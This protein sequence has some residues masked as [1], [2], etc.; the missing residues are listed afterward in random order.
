VDLSASIICKE[1]GLGVTWAVARVR[2]ERALESTIQGAVFEE[3][4]GVGVELLC[5]EG[6][7][8][9]ILQNQ[10]QRLRGSWL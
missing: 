1:Y 2:N 3:E 8:A 10:A 7:T 5:I 9:L 4:E 6:G